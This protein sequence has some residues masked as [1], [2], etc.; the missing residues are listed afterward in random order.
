MA[1]SA[2]APRVRPSRAPEPRAPRLTL[3]AEPAPGRSTVPFVALCTAI[4]V[5]A[6]LAVL[7]LN[8]SMSQGSYELSR[9]QSQAGALT[10]R[11]QDLQQELELRQA[12]QRL[13]VEAQQLGMVPSGQPAFID[14]ATGEIIGEPM[15]A[16]E[17]PVSENLVAPPAIESASDAYHGLGRQ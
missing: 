9:L 8:I 2:S 16:G 4:L 11:E 3:L 13:A 12:P 1:L 6:L 14:L 7:V 17:R 5:G 10:Q 15:P